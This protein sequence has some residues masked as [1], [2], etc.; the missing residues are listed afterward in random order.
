MS[1]RRVR[2]ELPDTA[3]DVLIGSGLLDEVGPLVRGVTRA[4]CAA[5]VSDE[6][7]AERYAIRVDVSLARSGF[8]VSSLTVPPGESSKEW[9]LAGE[10]LEALAAKGLSRDDIVVALGG[11]VTGDLVGF[12]SAVYLRGIDLVQVPTTLLAMVDSSVGGK[13]AVDLP[14][15]KNLVG[16]FKQPLLVVADVD[17]LKTLPDEEWRSGLAE[18]AKTAMLSGE[19]MLSWME[20]NA[21]RLLDRDPDAVIEAVERCVAFKAGV[22]AADERESG[23]RECLNYGHTLGHA[24]EKVAGY[25]RF[26]HG[27]A[28]AE[29]MRF[30]SRVAVQLAGADVSFVR[31]QDR[32]LD[33]LGLGALE[34]ALPTAVLHDAMR[35]DKKARGGEVRMVLVSEPG[36]W[37]CVAVE[38][39]VI[40]EHLEAWA[41][42]KSE[43][44][45]A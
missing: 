39:A 9:S 25:G 37:S 32:L 19:E 44:E 6:N 18:V 1:V 10:L 34:V 7:V 36:T 30:A 13:T 21:R 5:L 12:V 15:G 3:Y 42:T 38:R 16:A 24:I 26:T 29:G 45:G 11:G 28:V 35:S 8:R 43:G 4:R 23:P 20:G 22:V 33:A 14:A 27:A 17:T 2:V 41:G 40:D 31:R